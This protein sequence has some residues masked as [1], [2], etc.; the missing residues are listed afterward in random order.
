MALI[1]PTFRVPRT[2]ISA[3][4]QQRGIENHK[5]TA[6]HLAA[7][8]NCHLEAAK[9]YEVGEQAK[10]DQSTIIAQS[11]INLAGLAMRDNARMKHLVSWGALE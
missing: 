6:S 2:P 5:K 10:G 7:A 9:F 8:A 3:E 11:Y 1:S 4:T